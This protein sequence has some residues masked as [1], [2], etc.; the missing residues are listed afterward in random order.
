MRCHRAWMML[1]RTGMDACPLDLP[2]VEVDARGDAN[3][4]ELTITESNPA[5][6]N[7]LRRRAA[8]DLEGGQHH[9]ER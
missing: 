6:V 3:G 5:L 2:G 4:I 1:G 7:E 8:L 9:H